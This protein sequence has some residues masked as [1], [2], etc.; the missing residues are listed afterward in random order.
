MLAHH[1]SPLL[2]SHG[3]SLERIAGL[4]DFAGLEMHEQTLRFIRMSQ[5]EHDKD[6]YS[7]YKRPGVRDCW[8]LELN[9]R[10]VD[11]ILGELD[12]TRLGRFLA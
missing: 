8:T 11:E 5:A 10:I 9:E 2:L 3:G 4:F 6:P 1:N 12:G 7:V